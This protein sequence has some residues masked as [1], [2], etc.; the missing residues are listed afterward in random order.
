MLTKTKRILE[1]SIFSFLGV[2]FLL[3]GSLF[4]Y[5][6][7]YAG[8]IYKNVYVANIDLTG[9]TK[10]Q[11]IFLL[12]K[13]YEEILGKEIVLK[14]NSGEIKTRIADTGL[15]IDVNQIINDSYNI[16]RS[17][18]FFQQIYL[19][20]ETILK[21]K[22]VEIEPT[23]DKGKF[24]NFNKIAVAQLNISPQDATLAIENGQIK[25]VDE[26]IGSEVDTSDLCERILESVANNSTI[27]IDL[28]SDIKN[29]AIKTSDFTEARQFA[30]NLLN[31]KFTFTYED[32]SFTP[33]RSEI[34]FWISFTNKDGKYSG[35][36]ND[37]NI[38][39]YLDKIAK[40]FEIIKIDKKING[41]DGSTIEEG[42]EGKYL[43][44]NSALK[45]IKNSIA[46]SGD[47][48]ISLQTYA[49]A[50]AELKVYPAEGVIPG[51][52]EGKYVDVDLTNQKLC[53]VEGPNVIDCFTVSSG[54]PS[55][56]TPVGTFYIRN[57]NPKQWSNK[58]G[59]WMPWWQQFNGD[60]GLHELPEWPN[61]Y[62][63]GEA[64]LGTPVSHGCVRLGIGSAETVY[65]WTEISTPVYI[66]K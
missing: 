5:Q 17:D 48:T 61:G 66:H 26:K 47:A 38:Q 1:W 11:A 59:L 43:D 44:K 63:E 8:K 50:P 9:K 31:K 6:V 56:P 23:I 30:E 13:K 32:K 57:K 27:V 29:P 60:Y 58:Y 10:T 52:F 39:A 25:V 62:K 24:D 53:R 37:N 45:S 46:T 3:C 15:S 36:L 12:Q 4:F 34:G 16:G 35:T 41:N 65:N 28:K 7:T 54:K 40:N 49:K 22:S 33:T 18:K 14:T 19:S 20:S 64:H 2:I 55:M 51:R 21:K 42:R